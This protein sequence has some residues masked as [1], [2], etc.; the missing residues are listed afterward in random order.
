MQTDVSFQKDL[1]IYKNEIKSK[2][3]CDSKVSKKFVEDLQ[4]NIDNYIADNDVTSIEE[5]YNHFGT[6]DDIANAFFETVDIKTVRKKI[7]LKKLIAVLVVTV[8]IIC[9][10]SMTVMVMNS[11][12]ADL[13]YEVHYGYEDESDFLN[14]I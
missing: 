10:I 6:A 4:N 11:K 9:G 8:I 14:N 13:A 2:L 3:I 12:K 5:I 1:K 7:G